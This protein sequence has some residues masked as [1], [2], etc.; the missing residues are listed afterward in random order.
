MQLTRE[1]R[2]VRVEKEQHKLNECFLSIWHG[3]TFK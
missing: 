2:N 3:V 1:Q